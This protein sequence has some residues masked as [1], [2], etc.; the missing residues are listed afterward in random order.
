MRVADGTGESV[1]C[2]LF[3]TTEAKGVSAL[4]LDWSEEELQTD[5]AA[6]QLVVQQFTKAGAD[7]LPLRTVSA[8]PG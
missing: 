7:L 8:T 5:G 2:E 6:Q 3:C 4:S 1:F